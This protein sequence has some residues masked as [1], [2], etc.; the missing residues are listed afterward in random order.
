MKYFDSLKK[1]DIKGIIFTDFD[2]TLFNRKRYISQ[3]NYDVLQKARD[4]GFLTV[5]ATGRSLYSFRRV[6]KS[7]EHPIEDFF[8]F[9]IF[10]SGSGIIR[11]FEGIRGFEK[12]IKPDDIIDSRTLS[13]TDSSQAA[14]ILFMDGIDFM[15]HQPVPDNHH[16]IH[17]KSNGSLNPDYYRRIRIYEEFAS[18]LSL[19]ED[20][21]EIDKIK[22]ICNQGVSQMVAVIPPQ[23]GKDSDDY[24]NKLHE[25]LCQKIDNCSVIRT[26][27]PVDHKSLWI[28]VFPSDV[29]KSQAANRLAS[30]LDVKK[31]NCLAIGNDFN[32]E[33]MLEWAGTGRTVDEAHEKLKQRFPSAGKS[34]DGAVAVAIEE[35]INV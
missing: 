32:D 15:I 30:K 29:S 17:I 5:I 12:T 27:S 18:P 10:S 6:A 9:L 19:S 33:D 13:N 11:S 34:E 24:Y 1:K 20:D 31:E 4:A 23:E 3:N 14:E 7:L 2:G 21:S 26:T 35:F 28:E 25:Y 16:F 22:T 8:D